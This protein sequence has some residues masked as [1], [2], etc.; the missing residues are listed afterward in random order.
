MTRPLVIDSE[1]FRTI[2]QTQVDQGGGE[3]VVELHL[4]GGRTHRL[5]SVTAVQGGYVT[6]EV[7]R[8]RGDSGTGGGHWRGK[9]PKP[10]PQE[11]TL[12]AVVPYESIVDLTVTPAT[13]GRP[14]IGFAQS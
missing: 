10:D 9:S 5:R 8:A 3:A 1:Y 6:L 7:Y 13:T 2:L 4:V 12:R 11:E 14:G